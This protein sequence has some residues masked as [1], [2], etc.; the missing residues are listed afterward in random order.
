M[1]GVPSA[2]STTIL[3]TLAIYGY[4]P[5]QGRLSSCTTKTSWPGGDIQEGD[6]VKLLDE[7][8]TI[9]AIAELKREESTQPSRDRYHEPY[10]GCHRNMSFAFDA[11]PDATFYAVKV[12]EHDGPAY[13][14]AQ[15]SA[16]GWVIPQLFLGDFN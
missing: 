9:I 8:G 15:L 1:Q 3:G 16:A 14:F 5:E 4:E 11:V 7:S 13:S 6:Q 10:W 2:P 12:G